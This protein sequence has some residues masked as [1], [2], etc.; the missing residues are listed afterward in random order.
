M[1]ARFHRAELGR[2]DPR[3]LLVVEPLDIAQDNDR[4]LLC[5]QAREGRLDEPQRLPIGRNVRE[6]RSSGG[7]LRPGLLLVL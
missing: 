2:G 6:L 1:D 4:A 3:D 5:R 7:R